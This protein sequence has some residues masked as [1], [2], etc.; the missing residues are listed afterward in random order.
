MS[1][2]TLLNTP[3]YSSRI[4]F[5]PRNGAIVWTAYSSG[6]ATSM[7]WRGA[8]QPFISLTIRTMR[9]RSL[10]TW[11][12]LSLIDRARV[13][14]LPHVYLGYAA[15]GQ[16]FAK[17]QNEVPTESEPGRRWGMA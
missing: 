2:T 12:V 11:N 17:I 16:P 7:F 14:G 6:L 13:L 15:R 4:R 10:G 3:G 9:D 5:R 8:C 1:P